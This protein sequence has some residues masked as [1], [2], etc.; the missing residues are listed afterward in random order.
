MSKKKVDEEASK[1]RAQL[2]SRMRSNLLQACGGA[3]N[4]QSQNTPQAITEVPQNESEKKII[5][6]ESIPINETIPA[7]LKISS[8][9]ESLPSNVSSGNESLPSNDLTGN[10]LF[11]SNVLIGNESLPSNKSLLEKTAQNTNNDPLPSNTSLPD[12]TLLGNDSLPDETLPS[13]GSLLQ[14]PAPYYGEPVHP[15]LFFAVL[16]I[17][18]YHLLSG[19]NASASILY[20]WAFTTQQSSVLHFT[21]SQIERELRYSRPR[22]SRTMNKLRESTL[23][24]VKATPRGV[25]LDISGIIE[26][27]KKSYPQLAEI[28]GNDSLPSSSSSYYIFNTT[29]TKASND[30]LLLWKSISRIDFRVLVD[31]ISFYGY[32]EKDI[33][34]KLIELMAGSYENHKGLENIAYN[35]AYA[36]NSKNVG[37]T[38]GYLVKTLSENYGAA[39]LS[40]GD[41]SRSE[42]LI[43]TFRIIRTG[44]LE[45]HGTGDLRNILAVLGRNVPEMTPRAECERQISDLLS[46]SEDLFQSMSKD[47]GLSG[48][49]GR[50]AAGEIKFK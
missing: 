42:K 41:R 28:C 7:N 12:E 27:A 50:N 37:S 9:N 16:N 43:E 26:E 6:N 45:D 30:S 17:G 5:G 40:Y 11:R 18:V 38:T 47:A 48:S 8:S 36:R 39:S 24:S 32:T 31:L 21:Y 49:V 1:G 35:L 3:I 10:D 23:I 46:R 13:Y 14:E 2:A 44:K 33:S 15:N 34:P 25:F 29:T 4:S 20:Y 19:D 22:V